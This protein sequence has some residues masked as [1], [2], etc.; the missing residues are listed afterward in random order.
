MGNADLS[1]YWLEHGAYVF[2]CGNHWYVGPDGT[3]EST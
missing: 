2:A 3:V 1:S